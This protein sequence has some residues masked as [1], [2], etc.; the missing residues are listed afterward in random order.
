[1]TKLRDAVG[2]S[3][4]AGVALHLGDRSYT[5]EDRLHVMPVDRI[6]TV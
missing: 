4:L 3:F 5:H 6:W 2:E 1:M